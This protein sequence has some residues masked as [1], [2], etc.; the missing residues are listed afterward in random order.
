MKQTSESDRFK[1]HQRK[2]FKKVSQT[3]FIIIQKLSIE[4]ILYIEKHK[5]LYANNKSVTTV[6]KWNEGCEK[7]N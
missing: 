7:A 4:N 6:P 5:K 2:K 1:L 3:Y